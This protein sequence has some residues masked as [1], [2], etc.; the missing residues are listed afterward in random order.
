MSEVDCIGS[1]LINLYK[2]QSTELLE[3]EKT[4]QKIRKNAF[5]FINEAEKSF[6]HSEHKN[7]RYQARKLSEW[8][9]KNELVLLGLDK[10]K[11]WLLTTET[12]VT[13]ELRNHI[14]T[15]YT[16]FE[17]PPTSKVTN[18]ESYLRYREN[19]VRRTISNLNL[20]KKEKTEVNTSSSTISEFVILA[21]VHKLDFVSESIAN[22]TPV[23]K[24]IE[25]SENTPINDQIKFRFIHPLKKSP[26]SNL[27]SMIGKKLKPL[28]NSGLRLESIQEINKAIQENLKNQPFN[29]ETQEFCS[30]DVCKFYDSLSIDVVKYVIDK[31]WSKY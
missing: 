8:L 19:K 20:T 2:K 4:K 6:N 16:K 24:S 13:N 27:G 29:H 7:M 25:W 14:S 3:E 28:Q 9:N 1:D 17:P 15:K 10:T 21:K 30:F 11:G 22:G 5:L 12:H 18:L 31:V 23:S 26:T